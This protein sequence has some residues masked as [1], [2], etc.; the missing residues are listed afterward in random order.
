MVSH[1]TDAL[2]DLKKKS[3][4][5]EPLGIPGNPLTK[6]VCD[7]CQ[8]RGHRAALN[9]GQTKC[10]FD[11]CEDVDQ[12]GMDNKHAEHKHVIAEVSLQIIVCC[13]EIIRFF[14]KF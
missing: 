4:E 9:R 3:L 7:K 10:P 1:K 12:C 2:K 8:Y 13:I 5:R 14:A 11:R 6:Y